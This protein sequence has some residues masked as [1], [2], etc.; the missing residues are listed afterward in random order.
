[1]P[2][3]RPYLREEHLPGWARENL[4]QMRQ[5]AEAP[6]VSSNMTTQSM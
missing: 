6:A 4:E 1:M 5:E 3:N 2:E